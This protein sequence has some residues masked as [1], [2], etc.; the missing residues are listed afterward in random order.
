MTSQELTRGGDIDKE[1]KLDLNIL[2][3]LS[4]KENLI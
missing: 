1:L 2:R 4:L 3:C